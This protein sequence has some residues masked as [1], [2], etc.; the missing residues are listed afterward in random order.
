MSVA[1]DILRPMGRSCDVHELGQ[2]QHWVVSRAQALEA[3]LSR[4]A[5][6]HR[7]SSGGPWRTLLPGVYLM[8][9][10]DASPSQREIAAMLYCGPQAVITGVAAL[11]FY[12]FRQL[13]RQARDVVDVLIPDRLSHTSC[14]WL[15]VHRTTRMP[16]WVWGSHGRRY[17]L[18]DRAVADTARMLTELREVRALVA[19]AVQDRHCAIEQL[20]SE[21]RLGGRANGALLRRVI[22]EVTAGVRSAPEAELRDLIIKAR[23]P[24]PLFNPRLYLPNGTFL[25][26]P[27]AWWPEAGVAIEIDS[28]Q[29]HIAPEN[30]EHTM[31][32]HA[33]LGQY[34]IVTLHVTPHQ[35]RTH[36]EVI[37]GKAANAYKTGTARPHLDIRTLPAVA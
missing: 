21:L 9:P 7:L 26:C 6:A 8:Q 30:W 27:D 13:P 4:H 31:D 12:E 20:A 29:W 34:G 18:P 23:L 3:G 37:M 10:G 11:R 35:L 22:A 19:H 1:D 36:P 32:R 33:D 24:M 5:I 28:R 15:Q 25:A 16:R 2:R 17:A 14:S